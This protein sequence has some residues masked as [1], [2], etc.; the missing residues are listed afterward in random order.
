M[1]VQAFIPYES[2]GYVNI[3]SRLIFRSSFYKPNLPLSLSGDSGLCSDICW[4]LNKLHLASF[5]STIHSA[6]SRKESCHMLL[7]LATA[8][9][10]LDSRAKYLCTI[11]SFQLLSLLNFSWTVH[12]K[13]SSLNN[14]LLFINKALVQLKTV[15]KMEAPFGG[16]YESLGYLY[17]QWSIIQN[18]VSCWPLSVLQF[19]C[20]PPIFVIVIDLPFGMGWGVI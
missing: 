20:L 10:I 2:A 17:L 18:Q 8:T 5:T 12:M 15:T 9:F 7:G 16:M 13:F 1:A 19:S 14:G 4:G 6:W 11:F 3:L